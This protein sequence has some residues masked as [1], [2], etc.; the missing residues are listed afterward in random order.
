MI[1]E[2]GLPAANH[3]GGFDCGLVGS[4]CETPLGVAQNGEDLLPAEESLIGQDIQQARDDCAASYGGSERNIRE[5]LLHSKPRQLCDPKSAIARA[6][7][8]VSLT[9]KGHRLP[10]WPKCRVECI[11]WIEDAPK[12]NSRIKIN[13][14]I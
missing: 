3:A 10:W 4:W 11:P 9:K 1:L 8:C 6:A 2:T 14:L 5:V 7:F 12:P 13:A